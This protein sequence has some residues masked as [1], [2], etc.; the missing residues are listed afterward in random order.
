MGVTHTIFAPRNTNQSVRANHTD[1]WQWEEILW[2]SMGEKIR[3]Q[4]WTPL[5]DPVPAHIKDMIAFGE[6]VGWWRHPQ[7]REEKK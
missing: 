4:E 1:E 6:S 7:K 5:V 2:F 3:Q